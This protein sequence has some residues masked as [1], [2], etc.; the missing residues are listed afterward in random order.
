MSAVLFIGG[1]L[2]LRVGLAG[3]YIGRIYM[4]MNVAPQYVIREMV[5]GGNSDAV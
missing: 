1:M 5:Q 4:S 2:M 3:E